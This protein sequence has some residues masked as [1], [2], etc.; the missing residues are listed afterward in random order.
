M[1]LTVLG[2]TGGVG[3]HIVTQ[4]LDAGHDVT[5]FAR[6]PGKLPRADELRVVEG[7]LDDEAALASAI[8]G[9][10]A[11]LSA[12]GPRDNVPEAVATFDA[13]GAR[14]V[15][16]MTDHGVRRLVSIAGSAMLTSND[17]R[18]LYR[19]LVS[20]LVHTV[21]KHKQTAKR[22]EYEHIAASDLDWVVVRPPMITEGPGTGSYRVS[23][24]RMLGM[25]I[26][27]GDVAHFMLACAQGDEWVRKEPIPAY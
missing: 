18:T 3:R 1:K 7:Q 12:I 19:R 20:R 2:G 5:A 13:S 6:S 23:P 4:A 17:E 16:L 15:R 11:V 10:D 24:S 22:R 25:K 14:L 8:A 27:Q 9:A 21:M 26:A